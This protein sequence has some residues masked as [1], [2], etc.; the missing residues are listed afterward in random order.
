MPPRVMT[1]SAGR[2]AAVP[3]GG[4]T[5]GGV[6][7]EGDNKN[8]SST[9]INDNIRGD[10][11]NVIVNNGRRG[12]TYKEFLDCN[13]KDYDGKG[14]AIVYT[15]WIE[16][17]ESVQDISRCRDSQKNHA[18]V[19]AGHAVYTV[20]FHELARLVPYLVTLEN[21]RIERY[22]YCLPPQ[23]CGMVAATEPTMIQSVVLK[24]SVLTDEAI[25]NRSI[26]KNPEKR[27]NKGY[28]RK[29]RKMRDDNK[30]PRTVSAFSMT[31]FDSRVDY[32]F[33][34]TTFIPLLGIEPNDLGF[35]YEIEITSGESF[36]VIMVIDWLSNYKA[37]I[38]CHEKVVRI[39]VLDGKVLR[40]L[41][42]RPEEKARH[43]M[44][45]KVKE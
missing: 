43:L 11:Q 40:V 39:P 20:R 17:M 36:D 21:K 27:G 44:S 10:V 7:R 25:R 31:L 29:D 35:S 23:I 33:V 8:Q 13:P 19:G 1:R 37:K 22:M 6:G 28:I 26:K 38:I 45:A 34:S 12:C 30:R 18:M 41:G 42:E 2:P 15:C 3:R 16:K 14:G 5:G 4:G 9:A 24:V 32:S